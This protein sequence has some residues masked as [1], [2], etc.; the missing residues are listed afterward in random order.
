ME[1]SRDYKRDTCFGNLGLKDRDA[2]GEVEKRNTA[3]I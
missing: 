3:K 1:C 2:E